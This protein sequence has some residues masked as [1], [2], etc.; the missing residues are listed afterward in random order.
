VP[1]EHTYSEIVCVCERVFKRSVRMAFDPPESRHFRCDAERAFDSVELRRVRTSSSENRTDN[2]DPA[3]RA[4]RELLVNSFAN[5]PRGRHSEGRATPHLFE[6][7]RSAS[8]HLSRY[9]FSCP[10]LLAQL[11]AEFL[12][13]AH[14]GRSASRLVVH[15]RSGC[16][17][18]GFRHPRKDFNLSQHRLKK[19]FRSPQKSTPC[20]L[21]V[22]ATRF[23]GAQENR[24]RKRRKIA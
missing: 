21:G 2:C 6:E 4:N 13:P 24:A 11:R 19:S 12:R 3:R 7:R 14:C 1:L 5:G 8:F 20:C 17:P 18:F 15:V 10:V 23:S 16:A 9:S 22:A